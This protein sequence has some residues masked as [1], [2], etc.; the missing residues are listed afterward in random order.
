MWSLVV[1]ILVMYSIKSE[2]ANI[3]VFCLCDFLQMNK[4]KEQNQDK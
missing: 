2:K 4:Q 3:P 1:I